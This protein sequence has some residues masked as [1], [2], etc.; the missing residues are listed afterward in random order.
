MPNCVTEFSSVCNSLKKKRLHTAP[1][2]LFAGAFD[3]RLGVRQGAVPSLR[4][5]ATSEHSSEDYA[6]VKEVPRVGSLGEWNPA[7][8]GWDIAKI[9]EM[10]GNSN[11]RDC[12]KMIRICKGKI[13]TC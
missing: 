2:L 4:F 10:D 13:E 8:N 12:M 1:F 3:V 11:Y 6:R 9:G 5:C 7:Q